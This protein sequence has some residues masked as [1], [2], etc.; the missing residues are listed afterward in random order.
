MKKAL[1]VITGI[2]SLLLPV[3]SQQIDMDAARAREEFQ[4]GVRSFHA[5]RFNDA[6]VSF[7]RAIAFTPEDL[8]I[9]EWLGRAYYHSGFEDAALN[10]WEVLARNNAAGS[11]LLAQLETLR[12]RRGIAPFLEE[13]LFISRSHRIPGVS[14]EQ[15]MFRRPLGLS[16]DPNGDVFL[17]SLGTQEVLR[18]NPNGRVV[19]RK[20]GGFDPLSQPFDVVYRNREVFVSEMGGNRITVLS[21]EGNRVRTFGSP[22]RNDG[23]LLG[24]QYMAIGDVDNL[25]YV[26]EW[27]GRR[28]SVF[29]L[30]GE[31]VLSFGRR[32]QFFPGLERPSGIAVRGDRVWVGERD[33]EGVALIVFDT[34]GNFLD[35]VALPIDPLD[36]PAAGPAGSAVEGLSWYGEGLLLVT[37]GDSVLLWD[38]ELQRVVTVLDDAERRRVGQASVDANN[39]VLVTD[40]DRNDVII[41]EPEGTLYSGL[42]VRIERVVGTRFPEVG[43]LVAV[44]DRDGRPVVGLQRENFVITERGIPQLEFELESAGQFTT[45]LD[46]SLVVQSRPSQSIRQDIQQ[47]VT[48]LVREVPIRERLQ[49]FIAG[50]EP[51]LVLRRPASVERFARDTAVA[52]EQRRNSFTQDNEP[53]ERAIRLAAVPLIERGV[54]RNI[55]VIGDGTVSDSAFDQ[56]GIQETAAFLSNNAVRLHLL[57][58]TPGSPAEEL[59]YLVRETGGTVQFLYEPQGVLPMV[60]SFR[61]H[62][63]GRYWLAYSSSSNPDFGRAYI[64]VATEVELFVRSGRDQNGFFPPLPQ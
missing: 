29:T 64:E 37:A 49:L 26:T 4:W 2:L 19:A 52:L 8:L 58:V 12:Y 46:I 55:V 48:D 60:R 34:A 36:L 6:I 31:F 20:R 9:R 53:L 3:G 57:M 54:R 62:P 18:I 14:G 24:P 38:V 30:E 59:E 44:H 28:V 10:E 13:D 32:D 11:Y 22:G 50:G 1:L 15:T 16:A 45:E 42:D 5:T 35:R 47:A 63:N 33:R 25:L 17:V 23:S 61:E 51:E 41:F 7:T 27:G 40:L 39:R 43:V 21:P 56:G